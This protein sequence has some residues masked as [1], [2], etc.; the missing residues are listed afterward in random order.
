M[1]KI[2]PGEEASDGPQEKKKPKTESKIKTKVIDGKRKCV[3]VKYVYE[4][5]MESESEQD[6]ASASKSPESPP[7]V[8]KAKHKRTETKGTVNKDV[9]DPPNEKPSHKVLSQQQD[10]QSMQNTV[11]QT[12]GSAKMDLQVG[13]NMLSVGI[14]SM[15]PPTP[16]SRVHPQSTF[17]PG[18]MQPMAQDPARPSIVHDPITGKVQMDITDFSSLMEF[19][20]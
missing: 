7:P 17:M 5:E 10:M 14:Q 20:R 6:N 4:T 9:Q 11:V 12:T 19:V 16:V 2:S 18:N 15:A 3:H 1:V 13:V 8:K